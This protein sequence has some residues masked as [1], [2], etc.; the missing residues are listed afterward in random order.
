MA[1]PS[2]TTVPN[3]EPLAGSGLAMGILQDVMTSTLISTKS[4]NFTPSTAPVPA[5]RER[6]VTP[7]STTLYLAVLAGLVSAVLGACGGGAKP[8]DSNTYAKAT[9]AQQ[10]CCEHAGANRDGCLK[11]IVRVE[12]FAQQSEANQ[13]TYAC[14]VD[15][16]T[17]DPA[18]G[19]ATPP[20]AQAQID[21]IQDLK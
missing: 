4:S 7:G 12:D 14:V 11:D 5:N 15:H 13:A 6:S 10:A 9:S 20:S 21:C 19:H 8:K 1:S 16:F 17:C 18:T 2:A 3:F